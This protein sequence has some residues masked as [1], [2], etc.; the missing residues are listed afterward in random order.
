MSETRWLDPVE[1]RAWRNFVDLTGEIMASLDEDLREHNITLGDYEVLV[2][3]SEAPEQ[4]MRMCDLAARLRLTPS[5]LTRRLDGLV[6]AGFVARHVDQT[7]RRVTNA[8]LTPAGFDHLVSTAPHHVESVRRQILT[9][10]TPSQIDH[11][12]SA[13]ESIKLGREDARA[14]RDDARANLVEH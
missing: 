8:V 13:L 14:T 6:S 5:G 12:G 7:D 4:R 3:L 10:M 1:M 9:F 11:F 2:F